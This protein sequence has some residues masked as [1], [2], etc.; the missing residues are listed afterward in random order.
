M[1]PQFRL[2]LT[3]AELA[4]FDLVLKIRRVPLKPE[5]L[6]IRTRLQAIW[7]IATQGLKVSIAANVS[8][9]TE[10]TMWRWIKLYQE[11]GIRGLCPK[12]NPQD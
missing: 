2:K 4:E 11:K 10:R 9:V 3:P 7:R 6:R 8:N 5:E 1:R 12:A